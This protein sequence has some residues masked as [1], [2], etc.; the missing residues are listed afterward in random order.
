MPLKQFFFTA[1]AMY[2]LVLFSCQKNVSDFVPA[3]PGSDSAT[4]LKTVTSVNYDDQG[5]FIYLARG[6][7]DYS[8]ASQKIAI[9]VR[10]S[11]SYQIDD[12]VETYQYDNNNRLSVFT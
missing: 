3:P 9:A 12:F 4:L 7:Y 5:A 2:A 10:D 1:L 6:V 8:N 11:T